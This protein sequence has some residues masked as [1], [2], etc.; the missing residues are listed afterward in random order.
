MATLPSSTIGLLN[1]ALPAAHL[2]SKNCP[3]SF[4]HDSPL[5]LQPQVHPNGTE[6]DTRRNP[7]ENFPMRNN[8]DEVDQQQ[9]AEYHHQIPMIE[10]DF[11][12]QA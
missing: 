6:I 3:E 1:L 2:A 12:G 4:Q 8:E 11:P 7:F 10:V 9:C 5:E